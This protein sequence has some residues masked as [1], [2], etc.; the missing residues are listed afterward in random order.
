MILQNIN[1]LTGLN[2]CAH[3]I[4]VLNPQSCCHV[5]L[6]LWR[7]ARSDYAL[8]IVAKVRAVMARIMTDLV[9]ATEKPAFVA[10]PPTVPPVGG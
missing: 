6:T 10:P 3:L 5:A 2:L 9:A 1:K 8:R 4:L 7:E